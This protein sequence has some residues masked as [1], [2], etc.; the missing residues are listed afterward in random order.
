[1]ARYNT[2]RYQYETSPRKLQPEYEPKKRKTQKKQVAKKSKSKVNTKKKSN[3]KIILYIAIA[4][5]I[6]F[7]VSF[8]NAL[9]SQKYTEIKKLKGEL[10]NIEK[11][12]ATRRKHRK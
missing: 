2:N 4:F 1:M 5:V 3:S 7:A 8:R 10:S 11:E 9:I 12:K 6:L